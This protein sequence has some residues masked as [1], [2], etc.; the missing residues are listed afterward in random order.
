LLG[1]RKI[2]AK[3]RERINRFIL[4][5]CIGELNPGATFLVKNKSKDSKYRYVAYVS[6]C[7]IAE[8][9]TAP[10]YAYTAMRSVLLEVLRFNASYSRDAENGKATKKT[11]DSDFI[12]T[13]MVPS[14]AFGQ[15]ASTHENK[16]CV[17]NVL[18]LTI[19]FGST[20]HIML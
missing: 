14:F 18:P 5:Q 12:E 11:A 1:P 20:R 3:T 9:F 8:G 15:F 10:D 13:V 16:K 17:F 6:L 19:P 2:D 4:E 7:R